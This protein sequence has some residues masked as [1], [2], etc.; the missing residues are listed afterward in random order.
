[1]RHFVRRYRK[2]VFANVVRRLGSVIVGCKLAVFPSCKFLVLII[3]LIYRH[4]LRPLEAFVVV[5]K[6]TA[7]IMMIQFEQ[8]SP[9]CAVSW[10][11]MISRI[12]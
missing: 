10:L 2:D 1:M 3:S 12:F 7:P 8:S 11:N 5:N 4:M 9:V 6:A